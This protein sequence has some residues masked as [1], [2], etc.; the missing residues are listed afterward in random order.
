MGDI[1]KVLLAIS[2]GVDAPSY[3]IEKRNDCKRGL[4]TMTKKLYDLDSHLS[5][6]NAQVLSC[7]SVGEGRWAVLLDQTAFFPEGGGQLADQGTLDGARVLDVQEMPEGILHTTDAPLEERAVVIGT[8]DL[9]LRFRRMQCH[10]GEH[11]VSGLAHRLYGCTNVGFHMGETEVILDFDRELTQAQIDTIEEH[12]NRIIWSNRPVTAAYPAPEVLQELDYRSKLELTEN[13]RIVTIPDC[14]VCACCAPH[15]NFTG[16]IG[17]V[18]LLA[19]MRHRGGVRIWMVAGEQAWKDYCTKQENT[20]AISAALSVK[21]H[22]TAQGVARM[23]AELEATYLALKEAKAALAAEKCKSLPETTG[24]LVLFED[25]LDSQSM[26][27]LVNAGVERCG[28]ICAVFAG[29]DGQYR[30]VMGSK[31][32][33][34]RALSKEIH[35]AL[36][37][38]GGGQP[39]MIQGSVTAD[40]KQIEEYFA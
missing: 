39:T 3:C 13:V 6:F 9:D 32:V 21:Q 14:D 17:M 37:G 15:V 25:D 30:H 38:K 10:S 2:L 1:P 26:R 35:Q 18:K 7:T 23:K 16:E 11:V 22:E 19:N 4:D 33:D 24:N 28:G 31:T 12:A 20:A 29:K 27:T 34:L 5:V 36:G 40:R 8:L